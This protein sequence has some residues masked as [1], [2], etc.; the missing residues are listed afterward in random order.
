MSDCEPDSNDDESDGSCSEPYYHDGG[1]FGG[2][3][4]ALRMLLGGVA[5]LGTPLQVL[6]A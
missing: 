2:E 3:Y 4:E 1:S 6:L 5:S